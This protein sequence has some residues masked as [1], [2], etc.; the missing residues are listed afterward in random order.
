MQLLSADIRIIGGENRCVN[1][2]VRF[3]YIKLKR[4]LTQIHKNPKINK[5][6]INRYV[7]LRFQNWLRIKVGWRMPIPRLSSASAACSPRRNRASMK[8]MAV[9][10]SWPT[11]PRIVTLGA[12]P[13]ATAIRENL[14]HSSSRI[15]TKRS[16]S[17]IVRIRRCAQGGTCPA[18]ANNCSSER[19]RRS[20][21][22]ASG[23]PKPSSM[24]S[25]GR[26]SDWSDTR[27]ASVF[28]QPPPA[29]FPAP[30]NIEIMI[31]K[32]P[33]LMIGMRQRASGIRN[34]IIAVNTK[35]NDHPVPDQDF[36][37]NMPLETSI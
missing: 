11:A 13:R 7:S 12:L 5:H 18:Q 14:S 34:R 25:H 35:I 33:K 10:L 2:H 29:V 22:I 26:A 21:V 37:I 9:S 31:I 4:P 20:G 23:R 19:R 1:V 3:Y 16:S 36:C 32:N 6:P 15:G 8:G 30:D 27:K 24:T 28:H 17:V